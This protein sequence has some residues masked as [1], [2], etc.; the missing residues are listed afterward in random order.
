M[1]RNERASACD[2]RIPSITILVGFKVDWLSRRIGELLIR[3]VLL[4]FTL[5]KSIVVL[6]IEVSADMVSKNTSRFRVTSSGSKW[7]TLRI[8]TKVRVISVFF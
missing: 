1:L 3:R 7:L 6:C 8:F 4:I 5:V 2:E